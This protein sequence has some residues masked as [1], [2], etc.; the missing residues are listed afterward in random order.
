MG[1]YPLAAGAVVPAATGAAAG[2]LRDSSNFVVQSPRRCPNP[3]IHEQGDV[4]PFARADGSTLYYVRAA[5]ARRG[6]K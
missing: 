1:L 5:P 4:Y 3:V 6:F 2:G